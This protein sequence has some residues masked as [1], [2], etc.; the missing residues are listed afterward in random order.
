MIPQLTTIIFIKMEMHLFLQEITQKGFGLSFAAKRI[1]NMSFRSERNAILQDLNINYITPF[2]KQQSYSLA[3]IYP[4]VSQPNGEI[5]SQI[6]IYYNIPKSRLGGKYGTNINLNFSNVYDIYKKSINQNNIYQSGTL[7]YK[8]NFFKS[9]DKMFQELNLEIIK[10]VDRKLKLI[11]NL[12]ML[13]NDDKI[14]KSQPLLE[15]Q[16]HEKIYAN[17]FIFETIYKIKRIIL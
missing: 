5:G 10:K 4:Y 15:N 6:D 17:I 16:N 9:G 12:I 11:S 8:S 3:T 2:N 7:G 13:Y 14:L 1:E